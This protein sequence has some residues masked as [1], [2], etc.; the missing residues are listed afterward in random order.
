MIGR[1]FFQQAKLACT[2][3]VALTLPLA[4][5]TLA[6]CGS[7]SGTTPATFTI[8]GTVTGLVGELVLQNNGGDDL[9][10]S[11]VGL[12]L[13]DESGEDFS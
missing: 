12:E 4:L 5:L 9:T 2:M 1:E 3:A 7:S 8:S 10:I 11:A 6:A 13:P